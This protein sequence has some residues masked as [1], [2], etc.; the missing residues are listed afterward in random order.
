MTAM[1]SV[2]AAA[3]DDLDE[4]RA[5]FDAVNAAYAHV[6]TSHAFDAA[7]VARDEAGEVKIDR[8]RNEPRKHDES[9]G[10]GW[11]LAAGAAAALFPGIGL[12]AG[13]AI[14]GG[15]GAALGAA[16]GRA[17]G[18]LSRDDL[19]H[20]GEVL[21]QGDAGLVVVYGTDMSDRVSPAVSG[22]KA[23][24]RRS[25]DMS[26]EQLAQEVRAAEE[27]AAAAHQPA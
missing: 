5:A 13:L 27:A 14:G 8:R 2:L 23:V 9:V 4:A 3:F 6:G 26:V 11:G 22:A 25:A 16:A 1:T 18:L 12:L 21:D 7:V 15:A 20:L 24:V 19:K 17:A 10:I